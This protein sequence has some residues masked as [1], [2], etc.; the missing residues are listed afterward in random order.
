MGTRSANRGHSSKDTAIS[1]VSIHPIHTICFY[2][3]SYL[4]ALCHSI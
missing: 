3:L 2:R 1:F 4:A